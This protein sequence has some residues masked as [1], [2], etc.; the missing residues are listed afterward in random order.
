MNADTHQFCDCTVLLFLYSGV[1]PPF[2]VFASNVA[3]RPGDHIDLIANRLIQDYN[4]EN[5]VLNRVQYTH[6][7]S[8]LFGV[9]SAETHII[10]LKLINYEN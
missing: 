4:R 3:S 9:L 7:N 8:R 5:T 1:W 6:A 10:N 2:K